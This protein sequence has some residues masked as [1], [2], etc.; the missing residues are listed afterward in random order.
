MR[1]DVFA[2]EAGD[3][4]RR[5]TSEQRHRHYPLVEIERLLEAAG[6]QLA[7]VRGQRPGAVLEPDADEGVHPKAL[8]VAR[9]P[10]IPERERRRHADLGALGA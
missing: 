3:L 9:R 8:F 10:G 2:R 5:T 1:V 7:A 6:L 4:W